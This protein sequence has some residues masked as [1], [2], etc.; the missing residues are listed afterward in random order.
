MMPTPHTKETPDVVDCGHPV[1]HAARML[2]AEPT[3]ITVAH[4]GRLDEGELFAKTRYIDWAVLMKRSFGLD[5][6]RCPRCGGRMRVLG[7][8]TQ[9]DTIRRILWCLGLRAEPLV[10][11][12]ARD[13]TW[14]QM[15]FDAA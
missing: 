7:T 10:R 2:H 5:V 3:R 6:L 4:W 12:P 8:I 14:Q 11:A 15:D 9:P 1:Q 13:P